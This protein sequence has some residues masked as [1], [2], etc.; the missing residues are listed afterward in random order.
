MM[1]LF[2]EPTERAKAMGVFGFVAAAALSYRR[3]HER[4]RAVAELAE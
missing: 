1:T 3:L 2:N 4:G